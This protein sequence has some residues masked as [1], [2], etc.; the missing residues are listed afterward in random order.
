[1]AKGDRFVRN[2]DSDSDGGC[3]IGYVTLSYKELVKIF[4]KPN[5]GT[6]GYKV[7]TSW[8]IIDTVTG[9]V[10]EL[11]DY[12][13]TK[14]Y[15]SHLQSVAAFRKRDSYDWHIGGS[16]FD[17]AALSIFLSSKLPRSVA[18]RTGHF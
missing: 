8:D 7:S 13:E 16:K 5:G 11:Y 12:K 17:P 2:T 6:D 3:L 4:G 1:M 15:D 9:N 14:Q 10:I 18:V